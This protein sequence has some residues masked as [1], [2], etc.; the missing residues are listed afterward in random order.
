MRIHTHY[1]S[2]KYKVIQAE[3]TDKNWK[4]LHCLM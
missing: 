3:G 2:S 4:Q 1:L